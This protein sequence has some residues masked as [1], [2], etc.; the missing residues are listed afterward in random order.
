MV[1]FCLLTIV[2]VER[3]LVSVNGFTGTTLRHSCTDRHRQNG[4]YQER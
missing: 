4:D 1:F 3:V 2:K